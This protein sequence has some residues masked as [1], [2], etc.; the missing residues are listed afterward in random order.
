MLKLTSEQ[1]E[2]ALD[3][4][5]AVLR[6]FGSN[7]TYDGSMIVARA[8]MEQLAG[9]FDVSP[10]DPG[11]RND[12]AEGN[13]WGCEHCTGL[14]ATEDHDTILMERILNETVRHNHKLGAQ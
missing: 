4:V 11:P 13:V 9:D 1:Y 3:G 6:L 2:E 5:A 7:E 8:V 10:I 12:I 14:H